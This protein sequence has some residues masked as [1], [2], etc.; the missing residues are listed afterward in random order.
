MHYVALI[1]NQNVPIVP[2]FNIKEVIEQ[3]VA[4]EA[5]C[6]ILLALIESV[7]EI[8]L[9]VGFKGPSLPSVFGELFLKLI[10]R[11]SV[12]YILDKTS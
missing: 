8:L 1:V 2:I 10:D 7:A 4:G 11:D 3:G 6:E 9:I 5:L 12:R